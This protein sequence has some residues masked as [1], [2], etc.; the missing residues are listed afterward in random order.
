MNPAQCIQHAIQSLLWQLKLASCGTRYEGPPTP[1]YSPQPL[2]MKAL[3]G[4]SSRRSFVKSAVGLNNEVTW[5]TALVLL[6]TH[7]Q[8]LQQCIGCS[9]K[10]E[11]Y[12]QAA[13][14]IQAFVAPRG[15]RT[16]SFRRRVAISLERRGTALVSTNF[17]R[18][19]LPS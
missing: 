4:Y 2:A 15:R 10:H 19:L 9:P 7:H 5:C 14:L 13:V 6:A 8:R 3:F 11:T 1:T 12:L 18:S 16:S 17:R